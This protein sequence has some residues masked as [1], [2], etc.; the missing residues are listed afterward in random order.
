MKHTEYNRKRRRGGR[1]VRRLLPAAVCIALI[2][3][4]A[5]NLIAY[6]ARSHSVK[7]ANAALQ[8]IYEQT[9]SPTALPEATAETILPEAIP[10]ETVLPEAVPSATV[11]PETHL[12]SEYQF[13]SGEMLPRMRELFEK[14]GDLVA[15]VRIPGVVSL[16]VVYRDNTYYLNHDFSGKS[17][18]AGTLFLDDR[19]PLT[20]QTQH[21]LI[22]GHNMHDGS[23]F[24]L[25]SHYRG[26][27]YVLEHGLVSLSTLYREETYALFAVLIAPDDP[28]DARYVP[29]AGTAAFQS[30]GQFNAFIETIR[31]HS[32]YEIPIDVQPGDALLT[33]STCLDEDKLVLVCRR[34]RAGETEEALRQALNQSARR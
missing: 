8:E 15:W 17:S 13:L 30:E 27:D 20:A 18:A 26:L 7:Q 31:V 10:S 4:G 11:P 5:G 21:L 16:P 6:F 32:L 19:H 23:M 34:M 29:Y 33:L 12:R 9:P 1:G 14:N 28:G 22:H 25:L 24:G 3:F 2:A